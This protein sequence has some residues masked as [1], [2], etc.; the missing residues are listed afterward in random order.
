MVGW[1]QDLTVLAGCSTATSVVI[2]CKTLFST[3]LATEMVV[4]QA[5]AGVLCTD[6]SLYSMYC[7]VPLQAS[8][9][10]RL[11]ITEAS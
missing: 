7:L 6:S 10:V 5:M 3:F 8:L 1:Q 9:L 11:V 2:L 4:F